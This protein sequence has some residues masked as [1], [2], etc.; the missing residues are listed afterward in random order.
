[1][2]KNSQAVSDALGIA[3]ALGDVVLP[4][5]HCSV[6]LA[7]GLQDVL[8]VRVLFS[9]RCLLLLITSLALHCVSHL[10]ICILLQR[11]RR[12]VVARLEDLLLVLRAQR[13]SIVDV[14]VTHLDPID[15]L[16]F[17]HR[18]DVL[19]HN[20]ALVGLIGL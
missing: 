7:L 11:H 14:L 20:V 4:I 9:S 10:P 13:H 17:A 12:Q 5:V 16:V 2:C 1:M 8:I 3:T 18:V 15:R 6:F 19:L